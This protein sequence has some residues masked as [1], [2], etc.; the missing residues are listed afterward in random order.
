[1]GLEYLV[2][3]FFFGPRHGDHRQGQGQLLRDL[4]PGRC[5]AA[6]N[7]PGRRDSSPAASATNPNAMPNC[8]KAVKALRPDL[9]A[10]WHRALPAPIRAP[11]ATPAFAVSSAIRNEV[12][13][14]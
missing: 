4:V 9:P 6:I 11:S 8:L 13:T 14:R 12:R 10:L 3:I 5:G 7:R 1:M 2:I